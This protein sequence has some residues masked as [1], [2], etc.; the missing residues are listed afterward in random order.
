MRYL[1]IDENSPYRQLV[2]IGGVGTGIFFEL[3]G[4]ATL[5]RNE[6]RLGR[7][8]DVKDYCK[9]H[10]VIHYVAKL[11]GA[12]S[13]NGSFHVTCVAKVGD[14]A[15]GRLVIR[16]M[17]E[18]GIDISRIQTVSATPTLF[19]VCFQYPNGTG[20]NI[21]TSN[22]AAGLLSQ[23]DIDQIADVLRA[24]GRVVVALAMPEVLLEVRRHFLE[25]A[26]GSGAF[27]VASFVAAEIRPARESGMFGLI[28]LV[29]LNENEGEELVGCPF[30]AE[31]PEQFVR[32]CQELL[33]SSYPELKVIITAGRLGALGITAQEYNFCPA[34]NVNVTSTAGAGDALLGGVIAALAAGIPFLGTT[35]S[36]KHQAEPYLDSALQLGVLLGSYKCLSPHTIH[37]GASLDALIAFAHH[38]GLSFSPEFK[39]LFVRALAR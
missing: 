21:T 8:L 3:D 27:R 35:N 26:T 29:S 17:S 31:S 37:P 18:V 6:S 28:D 19:S 32:R 15:A 24:G 10:I 5:G 13:S 23:G 39:R 25:S 7:L 33:R 30:S 38:W 20:G 9:L 2:G 4:D 22:S 14:D 34:P 36:A 11:L 12:C 16:E 1:C